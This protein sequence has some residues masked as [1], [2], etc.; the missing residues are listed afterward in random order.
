MAMKKRV[1]AGFTVIELMVTIAVMAILVTIGIPAIQEL[2]KNNRV[3][4]QANELTAMINF[5]R[6]EA[7]RRNDSIPVELSQETNGWSGE[8]RSP[9]DLENTEGCTV[10]VLR[11]IS[12]DRLQ[13]SADVDL[14]FNNRGYLTPFNQGNVTFALEHESCTGVRQRR[15]IRIRP[16]G[17]VE[18][19][20]VGCGVTEWQC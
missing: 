3:T 1:S 9:D 6:N 2:I 18:G 15:L 7:L 10:G 5:A 4:A 13:L 16:S 17:Q 20:T 8:V 11:C 19:C 12:Y 14:T